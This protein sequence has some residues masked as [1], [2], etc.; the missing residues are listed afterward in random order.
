MLDGTHDILQ[1]LVLQKL[2]HMRGVQAILRKDITLRCMYGRAASSNKGRH[3]KLTQEQTPRYKRCICYAS[4]WKCISPRMCKQHANF[5]RE[6]S[7]VQAVFGRQAELCW[8][9][10]AREEEGGETRMRN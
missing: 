4:L 6:A 2:R 5:V 3:G 10:E 9:R 8:T 7:Q 1:G